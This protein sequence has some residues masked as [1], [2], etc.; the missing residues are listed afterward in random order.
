MRKQLLSKFRDEKDKMPLEKR[1]LVLTHFPR[2]LTLLE[3]EIYGANSPIW[4]PEFRQAPP[5]HVQQ[6]T[7]EQH[8]AIVAAARGS[9]GG[10]SSSDGLQQ[11]HQ[12]RPRPK[13]SGERL[14]LL[15]TDQY[16]IW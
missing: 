10:D 5:S 11:S 7:T 14:K 8:R 13:V 12:V 1:T 6:M 16:E 9:S 2:F 4:D 15:G 3:E